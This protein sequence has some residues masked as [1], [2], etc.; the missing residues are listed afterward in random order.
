MLIVSLKILVQRSLVKR[1]VDVFGSS[2]IPFKAIQVAF[3]YYSISI[4]DEELCSLL[5]MLKYKVEIMNVKLF[6][7]LFERLCL[8]HSENSRSIQG[9]SFSS[10]F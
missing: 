6:V 2:Q 8:L 4:S 10:Y 5:S 3:D 9:A 1:A 7:G